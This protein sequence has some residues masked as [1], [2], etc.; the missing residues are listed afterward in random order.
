MHD[1]SQLR[2][3]NSAAVPCRTGWVLSTRHGIID[4]RRRTAIMGIL[5]VTPDSFSDGG[6]YV[7]PEMAV[8]H[9]VKLAGEGADII[10]I[11]GESTRPGALR[12]SLEDEIERV[13]P[14][15]RGLRR[16]LSIPLSIDTYKAEVARR[17]LDEGVDVVNDISAL[18]FDPA[19]VS[20]VASEKVPVVLM[21]MQGMPRT[22]QVQPHYQ[23]VLE[24][25]K[26]FLR[27]RMASVIETGV[28]PDQIIIDPGIGFG[29]NL[30]HN[31]ALLRGLPALGS[32][33]RPLLVGPSR[34]TFL[35]KFLQIGPE[36]RLEGSL[37]AAVA[38]GLGGAN[39]I[40]VHDVRETLRALQV[41]NA[42]RFGAEESEEKGSA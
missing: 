3:D 16:A 29:K 39:M 22:M 6:R 9:G 19:M 8:A 1:R 4:M 13:V 27:D 25:V 23:N 26:D 7:D 38:A 34:K 35:G 20:L 12:V 30:D 31:L 14:V 24:E 15:V 32:L 2:L 42:L 40:R 37:A 11:G 5:N 17:V 33:G 21:H 28:I 18:R 36:D 10:D 41:V